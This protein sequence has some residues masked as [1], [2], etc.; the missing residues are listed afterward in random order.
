[1]KPHITRL[2][3]PKRL[4]FGLVEQ[5]HILFAHAAYEKLSS[6]LRQRYYFAALNDMAFQIP[7]TCPVCNASKPNTTP[8][9]LLFPHTHS[10]K[11]NDQWSADYMALPKATISG[12][13]YIL[14]LIE[15]STRWVE[16]ALSYTTSSR[17]TAQHILQYIIANHRPPT[18]IRVD[19][20]STNLSK[21]MKIFLDK[22]QIKLIPSAARASQSS[23]L[24]ERTVLAIKNAIRLLLDTDTDIES[25][26]GQILVAIR[27]SP[28]KTLGVSP[29]YAKNGRE[30]ELFGLNIPFDPPKTLAP[31]DSKFLTGF[32]KHIDTVR[33]A[34]TQNILESKQTMATEYNKYH[35]AKQPPF[36][37]GSFVLLQTPLKAN[38]A[39]VL[40]HKMYCGEPYV[41]TEIV[42]N[43]FGPAYRLAST[44]TGKVRPALVPSYRKK[45]ILFTRKT[46]K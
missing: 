37:V 24:V 35:K 25:A 1:M 9:P 39:S 44:K 22:F 6:G 42:S 46:T 29:F 30:F 14:I 18:S 23:G 27:A 16:M 19:R 10:G 45:T 12:H 40:T 13:K 38:R 2:C 31:Q 26:I 32:H 33:N 43:Q 5:V 21:L 41:I 17:E 20:A 8:M 7:K 4:Q 11:W 28:S 15:Q 3:I 34:I 36:E